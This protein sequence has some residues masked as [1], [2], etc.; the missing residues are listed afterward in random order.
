MLAHVCA[1]WSVNVLISNYLGHCYTIVDIPGC[2]YLPILDTL[3]WAVS[4]CELPGNV[5]DY[6]AHT[7]HILNSFGFEFSDACSV[8]SDLSSSLRYSEPILDVCTIYEPSLSTRLR[9]GWRIQDPAGPLLAANNRR[10]TG[11]R[12]LQPQYWP[13]EGSLTFTGKRNMYILQKYVS[14]GEQ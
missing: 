13:L 11:H 5:H 8:S 9:I 1:V 4:M 12:P 14:R 3:Q 2:S 10:H 7:V 6:A